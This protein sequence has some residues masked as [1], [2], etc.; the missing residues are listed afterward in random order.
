ME[1]KRNYYCIIPADVLDDE[2]VSDG[3]KLLYGLIASLCNE[4]GYCFAT[5]EYLASRRQV[6]VSTIKRWLTVLNQC[7]YL[8]TALICGD[9]KKNIEERRLYLRETYVPPV[10]KRA[11]PRLKDE[12]T[13]SSEMN[14]PSVQKRTDPRFKNELDNNK[15]NNKINNKYIYTSD[16][17]SFWEM[18]PRNDRKREAFDKY[19]ARLKEGVTQE[20]IMAATENYKKYI[21]DTNTAPNYVMQATTFLGPHKRYE[22]YLEYHSPKEQDKLSGGESKWRAEGDDYPF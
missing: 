11:D 22:D 21:A 15:E 18:Y 5:N 16:F 4:K 6:S 13:P 19:Q 17:D 14:R 10:Q 8:N 3:A 2:R 12:L 7:C 1:E 9:N 20:Q